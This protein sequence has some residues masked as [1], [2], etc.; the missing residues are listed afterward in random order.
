MAGN[1]ITKEDLLHTL[2]VPVASELMAVEKLREIPLL[3]LAE[4]IL[5]V[6]SNS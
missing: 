3:L 2:L 6:W 1:I 4:N 5:I